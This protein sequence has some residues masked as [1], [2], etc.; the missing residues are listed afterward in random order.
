MNTNTYQLPQSGPDP[1]RL[2]VRK[3]GKFGT[4]RKE[5]RVKCFAYVVVKL[6]QNG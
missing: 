3:S 4:N 1:G 5:A 6:N 2:F